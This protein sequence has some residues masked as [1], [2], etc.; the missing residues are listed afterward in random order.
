MAGG[1]VQI[2]D[3]NA[4]NIA[5]RH[6]KW[7]GIRIALVPSLIDHAEGRVALVGSMIG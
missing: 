1:T 2:H 5:P 3:I 6:A 4:P 7:E